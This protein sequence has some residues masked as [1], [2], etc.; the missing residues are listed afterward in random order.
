MPHSLQ[1]T[2][3]Q[4][5]REEII[6]L[7]NTEE[8]LTEPL[9]KKADSLRKKYIG[10]DVH[11][12]GV[13]IF[14]NYCEQNCLYCSM[15]EENFSVDRYRMSAEEI[16][17]A[18]KKLSNAGYKTIVLSSGE[19]SYYDTDIIAYIVY[20]IKQ[21]ADVAVTLSLGARGFDEY[22]TWKIA[23]ADR[24]ILKFESSNP[25]LYNIYNEK[26]VLQDRIQHLRFL[27]RI[28][29][30]VGSGSIVGLPKQSVED[31]ADDILLVRELDAD[32]ASFSPFVP[33]PFTPY[34][35][36]PTASLGMALKTLAVARLAMPQTHIVSSTALNKISENGCIDGLNCGANVILS[37]LTSTISTNEKYSLDKNIISDYSPDPHK[38]ESLIETSGRKIA[39]T[40]GD[41]V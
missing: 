8:G 41:P 3:K 16:I 15:R 31:I 13:I 37:D 30:R 28:G 18:A 19:D 5:S 2:E 22:R 11:L 35:N 12:R 4:L 25:E 21:F 29:Y 26:T 20:T 1:N 14:S 17:L 36:M 38:L 34:Q 39:T 23:G 32:I 33:S 7:L 9:F 27:K 40:K 10:D 24:Y 6:E